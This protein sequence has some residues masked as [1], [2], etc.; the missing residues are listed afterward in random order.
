[1]YSL[2]EVMRE[3]RVYSRVVVGPSVFLSSG[4]AYV[5]ELLELSQGCQGPFQ[6]S[7]GKVGFL[8]RLHSGK[9]PHLALREEFP[10]FLE[11]RQQTWGSSRVT[12]GTSGTRS[13][14]L[15]KVHSQC[16]LQGPSWDSSAVAAVDKVLI[17]S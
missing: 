10:G 14:G 1:M 5:G 16:E 15:R 11:L 7:R 2:V 6:G 8:S 9:G 12:T 3:N 13:G 17:W 4:D